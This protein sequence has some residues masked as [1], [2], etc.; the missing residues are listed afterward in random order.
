ML[1]LVFKICSVLL[2]VALAV[3]GGF[4]LHAWQQEAKSADQMAP[5][6]G[7]FVE[8]P[9]GKIHVS[10]WGEADGQPIV[11]THGMAAWGGLWE[12][13]AITLAKN[14]YRVIAVDQAPFGFSDRDDTDFSRSRQAQRIAS[15][16]SAMGL[17]NY[18]LVGHSYGGGVAAETALRSPDQLSGLVL[19]CPVMVLAGE[20]DDIVKN[21]VPF[22]LNVPWL[23]EVLVSATIT[24]PLLTGFL[25]RQFMHQKDALTA[26]H[27]EILQRPM[28][29]KGNTEHMVIWL[30]QFL[31]GDPTAFSRQRENLSKLKMPVALIWGE[32]D[33]VT[34]IRQGEE[35]AKIIN[36]S[37][38]IKLKN[39]GHMPQLEAPER[40]S[41]ALLDSIEAIGRPGIGGPGIGRPGIGRPGIGGQGIERLGIER[42]GIERPGIE[43]PGNQPSEKLPIALREGFD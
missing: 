14:G 8:T 24:N 3:L 40:F 16:V 43:R 10:I 18:I 30:G 4:R 42:L 1:K 17:Q 34:P 9:Y 41:K 5:T 29:L 31:A 25:T 32:Q 6:N 38:F 12:E 33:Q 19:I 7:K 23:A 11:M 28:A 36:L 27:V 20:G 21:T 2:I 37:S 22:P 26:R 39:I 13:T 15:L 35:L